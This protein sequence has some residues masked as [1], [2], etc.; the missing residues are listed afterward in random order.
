MPQAEIVSRRSYPVYD[1]YEVPKSERTRGVRVLGGYALPE[2]SRLT[3]SADQIAKNLASLTDRLEVAFN[4]STAENVRRAIENIQVISND[5]RTFVAQQTEVAVRVTASAD[6]ALGEIEGASR[7]ARSSF[8]RIDRL[9]A[10]AQVD[11]ILSNIRLATG[12]IQRIAGD[13]TGSTDDLNRTLARADSAFARVNRIS[14]RLEAGQG[15]LGK[16]LVDSTLAVRAG[17]VLDQL[18]LLLADLRENPR[19]YV[20]L[21]IF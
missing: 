6:S 2:F 4:D 10:D 16:L 15:A 20:R 14:S 1:Y 19:R 13:L 12:S 7:A 17:D 9:L 11:T 3:A 5:L 18:N 21:S 8:D